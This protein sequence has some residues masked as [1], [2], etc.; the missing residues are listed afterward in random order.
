MKRISQYTASA[1]AQA[2][3]QQDPRISRQRAIYDL[4]EQDIVPAAEMNRFAHQA[5]P[6]RTSN[7]S[8]ADALTR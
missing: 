2:S 7:G 8:L 4:M 1:F 3:T 6:A 5:A